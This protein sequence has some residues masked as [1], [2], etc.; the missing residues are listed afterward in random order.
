MA[1]SGLKRQRAALLLAAGVIPSRALETISSWNLMKTSATSWVLL[2]QFTLDDMRAVIAAAPEPDTTFADAFL[3][4]EGW[5][6]AFSPAT[7]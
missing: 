4:G 3:G 6:R 2:P 5:L 7:G 1:A